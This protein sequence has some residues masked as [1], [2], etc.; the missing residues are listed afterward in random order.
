MNNDFPNPTYYV[1]MH[2]KKN[3]ENSRKLTWVYL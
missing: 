1:Y 3:M 2:I